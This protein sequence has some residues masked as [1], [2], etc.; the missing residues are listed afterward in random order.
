MIRVDDSWF[1][2]AL[3]MVATHPDGIIENLFGSTPDGFKKYG[4]FTAR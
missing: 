2:G 1:M 4:I 3:A